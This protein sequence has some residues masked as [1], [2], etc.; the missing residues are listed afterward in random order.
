MVTHSSFLRHLFMQFGA[1]QVAGDKVLY[2][3]QHILRLIEIGEWVSDTGPI[4]R[5]MLNGAGDKYVSCD[6]C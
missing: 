4:D 2:C 5:R 6:A 3:T 1:D